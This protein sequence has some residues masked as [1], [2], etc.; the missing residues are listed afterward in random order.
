MFT[1]PDFGWRYQSNSLIELFELISDSGA[2]T[3]NRLYAES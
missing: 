1:D 2:W 3:I